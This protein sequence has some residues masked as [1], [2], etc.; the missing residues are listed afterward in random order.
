MTFALGAVE[1]PGVSHLKGLTWLGHASFKLVRG[2]VTVYF[3][4]W[5]I[6]GEPH[7]GDLVL[8]SHPHFDHCDAGDVAKVAKPNAATLTA[9]DCAQ[10]LKGSKVSGVVQV[11]RPGD[12][13]KTK[14]VK[15][16]VVPAYNTNKDF[17]RKENGWA[18]FIVE[19]DGLRFYHAG[20]TDF[21][22][23]MGGMKV[24]VAL[25]PVSGVYVMNAE[26]AA[27]A[28]KAIAP[29]VAV[30]MHYGSIVGSAA[31]AKRFQELAGGIVVEI[32]EKDG[33]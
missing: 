15:V 11:V 27:E 7:D 3:D 28:A 2:D 6:E 16:E 31:D 32:L 22:P 8:V 19:V 4:P 25:L 30:P 14:G 9:A 29:K 13:V 33:Q 20:D 17:H 12:T 21:I 26:E 1:M 23:E 18:G 24:D 10:K 5:R